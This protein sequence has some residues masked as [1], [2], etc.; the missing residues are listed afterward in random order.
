MNNTNQLQKII[1]DSFNR[2]SDFKVNESQVIFSVTKNKKFGDVTTNFAMKFFKQ[3]T[4]FDNL[5]KFASFLVDEISLSNLIQSASVEGPGFINCFLKQNVVLDQLKSLENN[6]AKLKTVHQQDQVVVEYSSPNIAKPFT[7]GHL[8]STIIGDAIANILDENGYQ[9]FRDNHL[10]DWGTQFGKQIYAIKTWGDESEIDKA[11]RPVKL[12]VELY[13]KFHQEAENNPNI[14]EEGRKWFKKLEEGDVEARRLWKK[15]IDWSW[16]E[17]DKIYHRLGINFTENQGRGYGESF[18]E[19]K[20]KTV[21]DQLSQKNLLTDSRGAKLVFFPNDKYPPLMIIKNDGAT[22]YA[23]RDLATDNFRRQ[24]YGEKIQIINEVGAEQELYFKQLFE[25]EKMLGWFSD[26]QRIHIKH[27]LY[28]FKDKKMS[29]RKG[30]VIWLEDVLHEAFERVSKISGD[31]ISAENNWKIAMGSLKWN[32]LKRRPELNVVFDWQ[33]ITR[34]DG[35]SGPYVM[36]T[37]TRCA[38]VLKKATLSFDDL[39]P[40]AID[41]DERTL[42]NKLGQFPETI[43]RAAVSLSPS[44]ICTYLLE[45]S[46]IFNKFYTNNQII[47]AKTEEQKKLRLFITQ[48]TAYVIKNGLKILGIEAVQQM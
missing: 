34:V 8:R 35:D 22:L 30:N 16:K 6:L 10:G 1:A 37:Y 14:E 41:E 48:K 13:V 2:L 17:F 38:S 28:R 43:K 33:E 4:T 42:I 21:I 27:G 19:D 39:N 12:L 44:Q 18:F 7:V 25:V 9:V 26:E 23:T 15:C 40:T 31:R 45:L 32:D 5:H 47:N 46:Q 11:E 24:H 36:Y 29:T 3:Q 20:M